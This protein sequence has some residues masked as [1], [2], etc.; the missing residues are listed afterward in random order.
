[1]LGSQTHRGKR[2]KSLSS[3][4][5]VMRGST[6]ACREAPTASDS[7]I[8]TLLRSLRHD[9]ERNKA[10]ALLDQRERYEAELA[11]AAGKERC[12]REER[13]ILLRQQQQQLSQIEVSGPSAFIKLITG[14]CAPIIKFCATLA[15][16]G[17]VMLS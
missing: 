15:A 10:A 13:D 8:I 14:I 17:S 3:I 1:M 5:G 4:A 7:D 12:V 11:V 6:C 2:W 16:P 9:S